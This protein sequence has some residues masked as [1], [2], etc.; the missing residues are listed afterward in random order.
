MRSK[1]NFYLDYFVSLAIS[2]LIKEERKNF[3]DLKMKSV[4]LKKDQKG[5]THISGKIKSVY[6]ST[7][8]WSPTAH[9][10]DCLP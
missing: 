10:Y 6:L 8:L 4:L 3:F 2:T 1:F 9:M 5:D 7:G